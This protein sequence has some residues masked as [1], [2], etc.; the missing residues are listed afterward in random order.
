MTCTMNFTNVA[1][2]YCIKALSSGNDS[3]KF[4][5]CFISI[6]SNARFALDALPYLRTSLFFTAFIKS[7]T[8]LDLVGSPWP[9]PT[10]HGNS[11]LGIKWER[12]FL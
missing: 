12:A 10:F 11:L 4:R 2:V 3:S 9:V 7:L 6:R 1:E 5:T 8:S